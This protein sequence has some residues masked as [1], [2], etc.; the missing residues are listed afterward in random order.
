MKSLSTAILMLL[1]LSACNSGRQ[2]AQKQNQADEGHS[3]YTEKYRPQY[4]FSPEKN[5]MNDPNGL[6]WYDGEYH[7][8]YQY[9]P[10]GIKW[11][12]MSWGHAVSPDMV[13]WKHLPVA[14][15]EADSVMIFSG[16][17]VVDPQNTSGFGTADTPPMVAVYAGNNTATGAQDVRLAYSTDRGRSWTK[18]KGNP[19]IDPGSRN[20]RDPKV[21]WYEPGQ[22]W[23]AVVARSEDRKIA[24]YSSPDLK[25][26]T[27][28][29]DF[30]PAASIKGVW[31]CPDLFRLPVDGD[32]A[33]QRWVLQVDE[34]PG[35]LHGGSGGQYF[36]GNFDGQKFTLED[37]SSTAP[38]GNDKAR[39][40]DYGKDFYA[41]QSW[42]NNPD[43]ARRLW[44]A[45]MN[46]W[47]YGQDIPT[48]PWRS[49][50]T[51]PREVSL[52]SDS[53]GIHLVQTPV[54]E[55]QQLRGEGAHF[56]DVEVKPGN[57]ILDSLTGKSL[58]IMAEFELRDAAEFGILVR[59]GENQQTRI[60]YDT[61]KQELFVD[62]T[63]SGKSDFSE[64]F[65]GRHDGPLKPAGNRIRMHLF[66]DWSSV[67]VFG[68]DGRISITDR[69][70]PDPDSDGLQ[71]Y[72]QGGSVKLVSMDVWPLKSAW[73]QDTATD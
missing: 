47:Q 10:Y 49:A 73:K 63:H 54:K 51:I 69:I 59:K 43:P 16:S 64:D 3:Y 40:V 12:H 28:M 25:E 44:L 13:H 72:T 58:E 45:W 62:R 34:N 8:F 71:L 21:M 9:N 26:W 24:F 30:G 68:N 41:V 6:T 17:A 56:A 19:V 35:A 29:S 67:E 66:V 38:T 20:F 61:E 33:N 1:L 50:M 15:E 39:W 55:L 70:F 53:E 37:G 31:E 22:K 4:H 2:Q 7:L 32:S 52:V 60:G 42:S 27:H 11:G 23:V 18:Y 14:L 5:W 36:I 57:T 48:Q 65:P 46:N